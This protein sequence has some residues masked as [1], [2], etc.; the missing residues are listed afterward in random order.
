M[1]GQ[2][3]FYCNT[4]KAIWYQSY[5]FSNLL[6][7]VG[8]QISRAWGDKQWVR[9]VLNEVV[10]EGE[11]NL[12]IVMNW[13]GEYNYTMDVVMIENNNLV[14]DRLRLFCL[15]GTVPVDA[16]FSKINKIRTG[17]F[18]NVKTP[19]VTKVLEKN[20]YWV[21]LRQ[22]RKGLVE[23]MLKE[24]PNAKITVPPMQKII[25]LGKLCTKLSMKKRK[26]EI[27]ETIDTRDTV[28]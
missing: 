18:F 19:P 12:P 26:N 5:H 7:E 23:E 14:G 8:Q 9:R 27:G 24:N 15:L 28:R 25:R 13:V 4:H 16:F 11:Q 2:Y 21:E 10:M 17:T 1:T 20:I 3:M 6:G 22:V